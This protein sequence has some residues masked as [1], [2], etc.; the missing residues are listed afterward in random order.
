MRFVIIYKWSI[1]VFTMEVTLKK[2]LLAILFTFSATVSAKNAITYPERA[3]SLRIDGEV[4]LIY[5]INKYGKTENIRI[6]NARPEY[7]F[8]KNVIKQISIWKFQEGNPQKDVQ[9]K[10]IFNAN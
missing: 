7:V 4:N 9:L 2:I 5:D 3:K 1:D 10:V 6:V 8:E